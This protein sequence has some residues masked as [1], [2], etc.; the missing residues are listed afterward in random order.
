[1]GGSSSS[2]GGGGIHGMNGGV[3]LSN[4]ESKGEAH[5]DLALE[6]A[7]SACEEAQRRYDDGGGGGR[8]REWQ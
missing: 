5:E 3:L 1:M 2:S 8:N 7:T 4:G 6:A